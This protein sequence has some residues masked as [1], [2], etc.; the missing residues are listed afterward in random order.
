MIKTKLEPLKLWPTSE[1]PA[2]PACCSKK[3]ATPGKPLTI[4]EKQSGK[5]SRPW[6]STKVAKY[7]KQS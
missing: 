5:D 1:S 6:T 7:D 3:A 2:I 4:F